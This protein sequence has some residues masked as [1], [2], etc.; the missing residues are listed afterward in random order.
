MGPDGIGQMLPKPT[1]H[2]QPIS[3]APQR[4][5]EEEEELSPEQQVVASNGP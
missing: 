5:P 1:H 3:M 4:K 2:S